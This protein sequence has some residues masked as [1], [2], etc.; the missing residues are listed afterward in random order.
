MTNVMVCVKR[1][2]GAS[3]QI[4]LS[5][6][7]QTVDAR[8]V[9]YTVSSHDE[10]AVAHAVTIATATGGEATVLT[11]GSADA[12]EQVR[13]AVAVGCTGAVLLETEAESYGPADVAAAIAEVVRAREAEGAA[14]DLVLVG[15]DAAD[16]G[17]FQVGVRLA[18]QL[19]RPVLTGISTVEVSDGTAVAQGAGPE[20]TEVFELPLPAVI[21]IQEGGIEPRYPSIPG[22]M[23]AKRTPVDTITPKVDPVGSGRIRLK[24]PPEQPSNVEI[25]GEG[26]EAAPALVDL[27]YSIG[28]VPK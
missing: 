10:C 15:N 27:L 21:A 18:Y 28:V 24:L 22:R 1:V 4:L 7:G 8:H 25:L 14:V 6:D 5:D 23:K 19:D 16:T 13:D 20:G 9:G 3:G 17:D 26:A 2:P 12:L 11:L